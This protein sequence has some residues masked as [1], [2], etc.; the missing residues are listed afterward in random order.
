MIFLQFKDQTAKDVRS[1]KPVVV[2]VLD[3]GIYRSH[4]DLKDIVVQSENF[5]TNFPGTAA[6]CH[7]NV[8]SAC[9]RW[10]CY[11]EHLLHWVP[12][13]TSM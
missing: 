5:V 4:P 3:T 8:Q 7:L 6:R 1:T 10:M 12:L 13:R 9:M 2:A 11:G